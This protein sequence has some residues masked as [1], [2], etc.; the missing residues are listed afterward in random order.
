MKILTMSSL[1]N[2][3]GNGI[4]NENLIKIRKIIY[5]I[6]P[7]SYEVIDFSKFEIKNAISCKTGKVIWSR[8]CKSEW[9]LF[10][11]YSISK[12]LKDSYNYYRVI[13]NN[14]K[15]DIKKKVN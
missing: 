11:V 4:S 6:D 2:K 5:G 13:Q 8:Q 7:K 12:R 1:R 10:S 14:G 15:L 3:K 9:K